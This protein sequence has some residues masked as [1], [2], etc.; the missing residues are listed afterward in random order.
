MDRERLTLFLC[1]ISY[2]LLSDCLE[3]NE[4]MKWE[5]TSLNNTVNDQRYE[6]EFEN[7]MKDKN[8]FFIKQNVAFLSWT[9]IYFILGDIFFWDS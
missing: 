2:R 7:F 4:S 1:S 5:Y 6:I 8:N 3:N 9:K